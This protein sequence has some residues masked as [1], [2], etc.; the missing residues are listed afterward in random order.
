MYQLYKHV[1][2]LYMELNNFQTAK[3]MLQKALN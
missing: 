2:V 1:G 3:N